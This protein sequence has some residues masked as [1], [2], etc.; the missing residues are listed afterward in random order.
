[1]E[2]PAGDAKI[3]VLTTFGAS[4]DAARALDLGAISAISKDSSQEN[5][6][7]AIRSTARGE[8]VID[9]IRR[10]AETYRSAPKLNS[11]QIEILDYA[12]RGLENAEIAKL[13]GITSDGVKKHL[14]LIYAAL[15]AS[16]RAEAS[17][18][19]LRLGLIG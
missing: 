1:M 16:T 9:D 18:L 2:R 17:A 13:L 3:L 11:R 5:L 14:K 10:S 7:K 15:G 19:A 4:A 8:S 6:L 12:S